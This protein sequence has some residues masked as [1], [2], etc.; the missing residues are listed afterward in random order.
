M[1]ALKNKSGTKPWITA[2]TNWCRC[3]PYNLYRQQRLKDNERKCKTISKSISKTMIN[4]DLPSLVSSSIIDE[5]IA[6]INR[7]TKWILSEAL[8]LPCKCWWQ[9]SQV[10]HIQDNIFYN[11]IMT[12]LRSHGHGFHTHNQSILAKAHLVSKICF[13]LLKGAY[14]NIITAYW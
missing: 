4:S 14:T 13:S 8:L 5:N 10:S 9:G 1:F 12:V 6:I 3:H 7:K 2:K 11:T